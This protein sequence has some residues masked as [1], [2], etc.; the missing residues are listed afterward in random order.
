MIGSF[1]EREKPPALYNVTS[2]ILDEYM[3]NFIKS[4]AGVVVIDNLK[5]T[6][7][8]ACPDW[9]LIIKPYHSHDHLS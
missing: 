3:T 6:W 5:G 7:A 1:A 4:Q 9:P 8:H 2:S